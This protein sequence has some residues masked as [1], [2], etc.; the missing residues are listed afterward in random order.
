[1]SANWCFLKETY[2]FRT[3]LQQYTTQIST[4]SEHRL[5]IKFFL[6]EM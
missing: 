1:M 5:Q 2:G 6:M 3:M 4:F